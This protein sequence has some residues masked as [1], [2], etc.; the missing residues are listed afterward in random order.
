MNWSPIDF[1]ADLNDDQYAAVTAEPGPALVLAGAGS[2]KTRTLTYRVA[3]LLIEKH[4]SP[5]QLLLLTFTNKAAREMIERVQSLT[6]LGQTPRWSGTFHSIGGRL[7]RRYGH[8][9]G[10]SQSYTIMDQSDSES[11]LTSVIKDADKAFLKNKDHP[12]PKVIHSLLSYARN[13]RQDFDDLFRD[14][15]P[16][17]DRITASVSGFVKLYDTAKRE[18]QVVDYDDLLVLW[19]KLLQDFP[20]VRTACQEHF[21]YILV[22]EYQ[23]TNIIQAGIIDLIGAHHNIMA[24]GDDAQCIY[25]WRGANFENIRSFPERHP[26]TRIYKILTNYRSIP[27]I[28]KLANDVLA[29]QPGDAGYPKELVANREGRQLPY[30]VPL[31]DTRQQAQ[32]LVS[33][34]EALYDEGIALSD[35]AILY[36]AHY[37]ALDTQ[38]EFTRRGIP[39]IITSGLRFFEQAHVKDF[40]A[41][42]RV[43][44]NPDDS[45]AFERLLCLLPKVGPVTVRKCRDAVAKVLEKQLRKAAGPGDLFINGPSQKPDF[46]SALASEEVA[47]KIPADARDEYKSMVATFLEVR[48]LMTG[49]AQATPASIVEQALQGWYGDYIRNVYP[50]WENR[51]EDLQSIIGFAS[52]FDTMSELLSQLVLLNSE[53]S[54]RHIDPDD[55]AVRLSTIHQAKGLEFPVVFL[56]S[57]ADEWLPIKRAIEEGDVDEE[58]RLFY[59]AITRAMDEL[60]ISFPMMHAGRGGV[61][62]LMP[63]RFLA[64]IPRDSYEKLSVRPGW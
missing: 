6:G 10:L 56:I 62:R 34:I 36:R 44:A 57:C 9:L 7:L 38:L 45:P 2:G 21:P 51:Q 12:K 22:D 50:D 60:Y 19:L 16:W 5:D 42:L 46:F 54:D 61:Q 3:W 1:K 11:L 55:N 28:L 4:L 40:V 58:R 41:Q 17:H 8:H 27:P 52:R 53:T 18:Q 31:M 20:E 48:P 39:F 33:R 26:G 63:S 24:V 23:D 43:L 32:F 37:Q 59:V 25:T 35:I 49:D 64:E 13:T 29:M 30:V 14:R 47:S 15:Y